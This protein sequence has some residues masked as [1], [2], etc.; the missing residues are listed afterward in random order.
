VRSRLGGRIF[1]HHPTEGDTMMRIVTLIALIAGLALA[2]SA[3][4]D[5]VRNC[6]GLGS[7]VSQRIG[8]ITNISARNI[9]CRSARYMA[10]FV[11]ATGWEHPKPGWR[12]VSWADS[13]PEYGN[14]SVRLTNRHNQAV[15][16]HAGG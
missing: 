1:N 15:R 14:I 10:Y 13:G 12:C 8:Y 5:V 9:D 11:A 3:Q 6:G 7:Y 16:F 4:A 2:S